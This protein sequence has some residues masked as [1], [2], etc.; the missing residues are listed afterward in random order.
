MKKVMN[1]NKPLPHPTTDAKKIE[2]PEFELNQFARFVADACK[3]FY[4]DPENVKRF[5]QWKAERERSKHC[6][7][8]YT[9]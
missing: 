4:S 9:E 8:T 6:N 1:E 3:E 2:I 5:E 7:T